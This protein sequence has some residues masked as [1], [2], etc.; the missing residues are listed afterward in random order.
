MY[1][2][3]GKFLQIFFYLPLLVFWQEWETHYH[4]R[5]LS[6]VGPVL[7]IRNTFWNQINT[8]FPIEHIYCP[9]SYLLGFYTSHHTLLLCSVHLL[10]LL[11]ICSWLSKTLTLLLELFLW[12]ESWR[13]AEPYLPPW[14]LKQTGHSFLLCLPGAR[15]WSCSQLEASSK[16]FNMQEEGRDG[17]IPRLYEETQKGLAKVATVCRGGGTPAAP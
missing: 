8:W 7:F 13:E 6:H 17:H 5:Q 11:F 2:C 1:Y 10:C 9:F 16:I 4:Q 14:K 15:T 12:C 3:R